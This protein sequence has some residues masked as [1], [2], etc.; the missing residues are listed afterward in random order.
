[1]DTSDVLVT[2]P[3]FTDGHEQVNVANEIQRRFRSFVGWTGIKTPVDLAIAG[4]RYT[5]VDDK[6][7]CDACGL[8]LHSW[9]PADDPINEHR[10]HSPGCSFIRRW[11]TPQSDF[12]AGFQ[13]QPFLDYP[14]PRYPQYKEYRQRLDSFDGWPY[15]LEHQSPANLARA[16][17]FFHNVPDRVKCF[18]C[19]LGLRDWD[20]TDYP[21]AC[22]EEWSPDC[23]FIRSYKTQAQQMNQL[24]HRALP[25]AEHMQETTASVESVKPTS[26]NVSSPISV[27]E[28]AAIT[29]EAAT[30]VSPASTGA[31][32]KVSA[33]TTIV[34]APAAATKAEA[35]TSTEVTAAVVSTVGSVTT[36][37]PSQAKDVSVFM[38]NTSSNTSSVVE[39]SSDHL[40]DDIDWSSPMVK[41]TMEMGCSSELIQKFEKYGHKLSAQLK[42]VM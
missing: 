26:S 8:R 14:L 25:S 11:F 3:L 2:F 7:H 34:A 32:T 1:M 21:M 22:H 40:L 10:R 33:V 20:D 36:S 29:R 35:V 9:L 15:G 13:T 12:T 24:P 16:G 6:V 28:A 5:G 38:K 18:Q 30:N 23:P 17:F 41:A 4:F 19:G 31:T 39:K 27:V 37:I 42:S